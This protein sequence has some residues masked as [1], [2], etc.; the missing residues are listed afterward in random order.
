MSSNISWRRGPRCLQNM[1]LYS[2][3]FKIKNE[4]LRIASIPKGSG[5][6]NLLMGCECRWL[7]F[8][9][10]QIYPDSM[11]RPKWIERQLSPIKGPSSIPKI[12]E[13]CVLEHELSYTEATE[14]QF[15]P[16]ELSSDAQDLSSFPQE[17]S[18]ALS[19]F[20]KEFSCE[21]SVTE[22][23]LSHKMIIQEI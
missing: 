4:N 16:S 2:T 1:P 10:G 3:V 11:T 17:L 14:V 7:T 5:T 8:P 13:H 23:C 19:W 6:I 18:W 12:T 15:F 20:Q 21:E 22:F 9:Y